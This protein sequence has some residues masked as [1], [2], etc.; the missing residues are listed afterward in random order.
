MSLNYNH[1]HQRAGMGKNVSLGFETCCTSDRI[2]SSDDRFHISQRC[3]FFPQRLAEPLRRLITQTPPAPNVAENIKPPHWNPTPPPRRERQSVSAERGGLVFDGTFHQRTADYVASLTAHWQTGRTQ[4]LPDPL[5][6]SHSLSR[7][8]RFDVR[9]PKKG[10]DKGRNI[11]KDDLYGMH[12]PH[13]GLPS[14]RY[15]WFRLYNVQ[16]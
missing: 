11:K 4:Y 6:W 10:E 7:H 16:I 2:I 12:S 8:R 5:G 9:K 3:R 13:T 15:S 14:S 1:T